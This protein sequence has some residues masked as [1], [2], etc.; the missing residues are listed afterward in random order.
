MIDHIGI[1]VSNYQRAKQ[2][3]SAALLPLG[4]KLYIEYGETAGFDIELV[5]GFL[6]QPGEC[7]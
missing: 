3:Y 1:D 5:S 4:Y 6:D 2:F 7:H